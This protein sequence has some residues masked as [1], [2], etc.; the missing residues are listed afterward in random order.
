MKKIILASTAVI[1][2][3]GLA[4]CLKGVGAKSFEKENSF[5]VDRIE[6]IEINKESW[7]IEIKNTKSKKITIAVEGKQEDKKKDPVTIKDDEKKIVVNQKD[8]KGGFFEGFSFGKKGTI[9]ISI[10]EDGIDTITMNN[11][12]GDIK[13]NDVTTKNLVISNGSGT[14]KIEGLSANKGKFISKDGEFSLKNSSL[15]ELNIASTTGDNYIT[16]VNSPEIKVTSKDGEVSI[17]DIKEGK[18]LFVETKSGDIAVSY[19]K[20]PTSLAF[21]A[22]SDSSDITVNLDGFKKRKNTGNLKEGM[23]GNGTNKVELLSRKGV[24]NVK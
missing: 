4:F 5:E 20:A 22:N 21:T 16:N 1:V 14:G 7:N 3:G 15:K 23:I 9:Y 18:S 13:M 6:D 19:K 2:I 12:S 17:K 10:P 24:I 11:S 8:Q